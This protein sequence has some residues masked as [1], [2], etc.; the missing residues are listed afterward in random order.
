MKTILSEKYILAYEHA[1]PNLQIDEK[2][3]QM[4]QKALSL[5]FDEGL[6]VDEAAKRAFPRDYLF[7]DDFK[8]V[9][10]FIDRMMKDPRYL[11]RR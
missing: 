1:D 9:R 6:Q 4:I 3:E 11:N 7:T 2:H 10:T 8:Y 5:I